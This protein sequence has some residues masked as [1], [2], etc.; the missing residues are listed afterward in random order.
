MD[1]LIPD[2]APV[3]DVPDG[4][5]PEFHAA[6]GKYF[7]D[8]RD[9]IAEHVAAR[10]KS[11]MDLINE[12]RAARGM[13][14]VNGMPPA[15]IYADANAKAGINS[16]GTPVRQPDEMRAHDPNAETF[17]GQQAQ[18]MLD[19]GRFAAPIAAEA[20]GVPALARGGS[21]M[22]E[23]V[24]SGRPLQAIAGVGEA[25]LGAVGAGSLARGMNGAGNALSAVA[26]KIYATGPRVA[27]TTA[28]VAVPNAALAAQDDATDT[29]KRKAEYV[30]KHPA[31]S[32]LTD[33]LS[34]L[35]S[36]DPGLK[37][38]MAQRDAQIKRLVPLDQKNAL[39]KAQADSIRANVAVVLNGD[40]GKG[41]INGQIENYR[42]SGPLA[43][44][45]EVLNA[46][47]K[48]A[49]DNASE[50]FLANA[51]FRD[52]HPGVAEGLGVGG[53][54]IAGGLS[55]ANAI[56]SNM[57]DRL[58]TVPSINRSADAVER[59]AMGSTTQPGR[60]A[61]II[62]AKPQTIA[63]NEPAF[64]QAQRTLTNK[65]DS[66]GD[67]PSGG[68][69]GNAAMGTVLSQEARVIPEE[70]DAFAFGPGH[71]T[72]DAARGALSDPKYWASGMV[73]SMLA[74]GSAASVGKLAGNL[75]TA[76]K[77][78]LARAQTMASLKF[79]T[80]MPKRQLPA[81]P[82]S[83]FDR[84]GNAGMSGVEATFERMGL[85]RY[86]NRAPTQPGS[87]PSPAAKTGTEVTPPVGPPGEGPTVQPPVNPPGPGPR[88]GSQ[89][90][91][92]PSKSYVRSPEQSATQS[93][94]SSELGAG[95][96]VPG[97]GP[98]TDYLQ[99]QGFS[100]PVV[101]SQNRLDKAD[102]MARSMKASGIDDATTSKV[103]ESL[104]K[105]GKYGLPGI[106][107]GAS[108]AFLDDNP[109]AEPTHHSFRQTRDN[110]TGQYGT[111]K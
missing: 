3:A 22:V 12:Q 38:L 54:L 72:G 91:R 51:P 92:M 6:V 78:D 41:G 110:E 14:P 109:D 20:T 86:G 62:G 4:V 35:D 16:D 89:G 28:A 37:D 82:P 32:A 47:L 68:Y 77:P 13:A 66:R 67:N 103:M 7:N 10:P 11:N 71:P 48:N 69:L 31:V 100:K 40:D 36:A 94:I 98:V 75:A 90:G 84:L 19:V 104:M 93:Y 97:R 83:L 111:F 80:Q 52:R 105:S 81:P 46:Q 34:Q 95:K 64:A 101:P 107:A 55:G 26:D 63:P 23:G 108:N 49:Q 96:D 57:A 76:Q 88:P 79:D 30:S 65:L 60:L 5:R 74:G 25:A 39:S 27:A 8:N 17:E 15:N 33:Q 70:A 102:E 29:A 18:T 73:P 45:H 43:Q 61:S 56:K 106:A 87:R 21:N 9:L 53:A 99:Q 85:D 44:H 59:A 42:Q 58:V 24:R 1:T 2:A 50:E